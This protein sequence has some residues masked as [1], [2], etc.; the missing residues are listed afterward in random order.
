MRGLFNEKVF[1]VE[2]HYKVFRIYDQKR[3]GVLNDDGNFSGSVF[4][5]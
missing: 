3:G 4:R 1:L 2:L 5:C